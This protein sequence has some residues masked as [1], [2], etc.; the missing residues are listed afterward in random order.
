MPRLSA[1]KR[2]P[3]QF[4][5]I[6][7]WFLIVPSV[8]IS[9]GLAVL[10]YWVRRDWGAFAVVEAIAVAFSVYAYAEL[11]GWM[12]AYRRRRREALQ[13]PG[14]VTWR[15][16]RIGAFVMLCAFG[17][18]DGLFTAFAMSGSAW[19]TLAALAALVVSYFLLVMFL[20][21]YTL[22][23]EGDDVVVK[24]G[25]LPHPGA[26]TR[27]GFDALSHVD[28]QC[29][30]HGRGVAYNLVLGSPGWPDQTLGSVATEEEALFL[31]EKIDVLLASTAADPPSDHT[32]TGITPE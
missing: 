26:R 16:D 7:A 24:S 32:G 4:H 15:S 6:F 30:D 11:T 17:S 10:Q 12:T 3:D 8:G 18:L 22:R 31:A 5:T 14:T 27:A 29:V 21:R 9:V 20:N 28:V 25:P 1:M 13:R 23:V 2:R 19:W